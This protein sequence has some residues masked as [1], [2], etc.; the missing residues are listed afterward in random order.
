MASSDASAAASATS[1]VPQLRRGMKLRSCISAYGYVEKKGKKLILFVIAISPGSGKIWRVF[2]CYTH[3]VNLHK[4]LE[5]EF[6]CDEQ[7]PD[8]AG[9]PSTPDTR[10]THLEKWLQSV[11]EFFNRTGTDILDSIGLAKFVMH[12]VNKVPKGFKMIWRMDAQRPASAPP[13]RLKPKSSSASSK[14]EQLTVNDFE[15]IKVIGKGSF[16]KVLLV[17]RK[18][19]QTLYAM[20]T[21]VKDVIAER[22]QVFVCLSV[23]L[24]VCLPFGACYFFFFLFLHA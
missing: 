21:L 16:A 22:K 23:C 15:M 10:R 13:M 24:Y 19:F 11:L 1:D 6:G 2:R 9:G 8:V 7:P 5:Q 3:F 14:K 18:G 4:E 17:R 20:K 12:G